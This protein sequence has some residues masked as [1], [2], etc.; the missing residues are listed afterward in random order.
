MKIIQV[1]NIVSH[2]Q[3]PLARELCGLV[4]TENFRFAA[5]QGVDPSRTENGWKSDYSE[6]WIIRPSESSDAREEFER[7][8]DEADVV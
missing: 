1:T 7:F 4:G 3:L 6:S 5:M 8:W 2:H